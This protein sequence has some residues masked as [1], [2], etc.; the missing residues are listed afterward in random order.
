MA[1]EKEFTRGEMWGAVLAMA[2]L[3]CVL[4]YIT[5]DKARE[6][7]IQSVKPT[8]CS[9]PV[10]SA[11]GQARDESAKEIADYVVGGCVSTGEFQVGA[12]TFICLPKQEM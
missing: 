10:A 7:G 3:A 9:I 5:E 8:D 11:M 2:L 12:M 4:V 6:R 1:K